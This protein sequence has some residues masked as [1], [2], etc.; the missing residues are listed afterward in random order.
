MSEQIEMLNVT[1]TFMV[2]EIEVEALRGI[3]I[4]IKKGEFVVILGASGSGKTTMLNQIGGIDQP[5][6]GVVKIA[7]NDITNYTD[8][9]MT[10]HRKEKIGWI[11]QF[12]N[13]IPSL[14]ARENVML[15][16]EMMGD[17]KNQQQRADEVL[18]IIGLAGMEERFPAQLS[19]GQQQ[20][21]A[22]A[23]ALVKNPEIIVADEPTG[24]LDRSTGRAIVDLMLK[25]CREKS[26]TF[27]IVTH[28]PSLTSVADRLL[29]MED[30]IL[31]EDQE[32][33]NEFL[34]IKR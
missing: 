13:L 19:G 30:G 1:R 28:D 26:I 16:L 23:R 25:L 2:G 10:R 34:S 12:H 22:I 14:N 17:T 15:A 6:L 21:I 24:N 8:K 11:F 3:S 31:Y 33:I 20:R 5:T 27:C 29:Y 7:G 18:G 9:Q 32:K 4:S